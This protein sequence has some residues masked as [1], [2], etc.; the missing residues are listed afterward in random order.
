[1]ITAS[2]AAVCAF[3]TH[4]NVLLLIQ[5]ICFVMPSDKLLKMCHAHTALML[6][7]LTCKFAYFCIKNLDT[8]RDS[9]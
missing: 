3:V 7:P 4:L 9:G 2:V 6:G 8:P 5:L 1:M